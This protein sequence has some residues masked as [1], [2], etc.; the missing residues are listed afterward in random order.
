M[1]ESSIKN[2]D[3]DTTKEI[4]SDRDQYLDDMNNVFSVS[5]F[6]LFFFIHFL[7]CFRIFSGTLTIFFII[8]FLHMKKDSLL[9]TFQNNFNYVKYN[10]DDSTSTTESDHLELL[11]IIKK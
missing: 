1:N 3:D 4:N 11:K 10:D 7:I 6:F 8:I 5:F 9:N 2:L